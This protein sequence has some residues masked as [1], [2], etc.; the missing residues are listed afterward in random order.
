MDFYA[1]ARENMVECQLMPDGVT[2]E[3]ILNAYLSVP[4]EV[5]LPEQK[6][7][8]AY[9]DEDLMLDDKR[10]I[11]EPSTHARMIQALNIS[12]DE[13]VLD[14]ACAT[15]YSSAI[16]S[17]LSNTVVALG[18]DEDISNIA[19]ENCENLGIYNVA[20]FTGELLSC[21]PD[22]APYSAIIFNGALP[23]LPEDVLHNLA[24]NGRLIYIERKPNAHIGSV[25]MIHK[26]KDDRYSRLNLFDAA[27]PYLP[28]FDQEEEFVF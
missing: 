3:D 17:Y 19:K 21:C 14:V 7:D 25:I 24:V 11:L 23:R 1:K 15:G 6:R 4:R 10:F 8:V 27:T 18:Q 5:F 13:A 22:Y 26:L 12:K 28:G 16:L 9:I 2:D 20:F